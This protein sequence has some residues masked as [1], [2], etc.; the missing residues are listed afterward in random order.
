[1]PDARLVIS[2]ILSVALHAAAAVAILLDDSHKN[3][4]PTPP[5]WQHDPENQIEFP[6]PP[7]PPPQ[8]RLGITESRNA[9]V[10]WIGFD[11]PTPHA[12]PQGSV[13]QAALE[14]AA[15]TSTPSPTPTPTTPPSEPTPENPQPQDQ[16]EPDPPTPATL[17]T[18][19]EDDAESDQ[20]PQSDRDDPL[21]PFAIAADI[22]NNQAEPTTENPIPL[23]IAAAARQLEAA[24]A[25]ARQLPE[26]NAAEETQQP[27]TQTA[28]D[29]NPNQQQP[30][31]TPPPQTPPT[32]P[33]P[34]QPP[35]DGPPAPNTNPSDRES[36]PS[37]IARSF[38]Y[39]P[40]RPLAVEGLEIR[41]VRPQF[42]ALTRLSGIARNPIVVIGFGRDGRAWDAQITRSSGHN[43]VDRQIR[44]TALRWTAAGKALADLP[45]DANPA[46]DQHARLNVQI[47]IILR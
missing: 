46:S 8:H 10:A 21:L 14:L 4:P 40:G 9:S 27:T 16:P 41:T 33:Q 37:A 25:R 32:P 43:E 29:S 22:Q 20:S 15:A 44:L 6:P 7:P 24:I 31:P 34:T 5:P 39:Q 13:D 26:Q 12:A 42:D 18:N 38:T 19:T 45:A 11:N 28:Q 30:N 1:M 2:L 17:A 47:E 36:D 23:A 35:A 3:T